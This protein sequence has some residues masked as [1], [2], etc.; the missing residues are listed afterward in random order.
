MISMLRSMSF[1]QKVYQYCLQLINDKISELENNL[2]DLR[3]SVGNETKS[4]AGD[5]YETAR[6]MLHIEQENT[7]RQLQ[8]LMQQKVRLER[9]DI[10]NSTPHITAG[11]LIMTSKGYI[12]IGPGLG[13]IIIDG[14]PVICISLHSP[15][16]QK[17]AGLQEGA[18]AVVNGVSYIITA[19]F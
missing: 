10:T 1:K 14:E 6:A 4:T 8:E 9:I 2:K 5:K 16:G 13:K 17:L 18:T 11:S 7:G 15:L 3:E 12:F 19:H